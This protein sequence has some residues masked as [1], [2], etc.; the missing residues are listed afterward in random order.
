MIVKQISI[1]EFKA[2]CAEEIRA[3]ETADVTLEL[4]RHGKVIAK[5]IQPHSPTT[6]TAGKTVAD[7]MGS[8]RHFPIGLTGADFDEPTFSPEDWEEHPANEI[9]P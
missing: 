5:V 6:T 7:L 8:L 9:L 2:H 3:V 1:S 4:T